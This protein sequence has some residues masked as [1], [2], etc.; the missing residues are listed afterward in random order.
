MAHAAMN[1]IIKILAEWQLG[2]KQEAL[3][4]YFGLNVIPNVFAGRNELK[5]T[6]CTTKVIISEG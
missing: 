6:F 5:I 3:F 4:F 1:I 2:S